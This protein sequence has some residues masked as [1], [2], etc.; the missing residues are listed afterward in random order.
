MISYAWLLMSGLILLT[1]VAFCIAAI[2][3]SGQNK[4][5]E[6]APLPEEKS[7]TSI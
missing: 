3:N 4:K 6:G 7:K 5:D 2:R 1:S